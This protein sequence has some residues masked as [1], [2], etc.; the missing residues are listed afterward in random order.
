MTL[1]ILFWFSGRIKKRSS[2]IQLNISC[3]HACNTALALMDNHLENKWMSWREL[4]KWTPQFSDLYIIMLFLWRAL[5]ERV[6]LVCPNLW[7]MEGFNWLRQEP[8]TFHVGVF[9]KASDSF[10]HRCSPCILQQGVQ[11]THIWELP[12]CFRNHRWKR[13]DPVPLSLYVINFYE[14]E[15][16]FGPYFRLHFDLC[17]RYLCQWIRTDT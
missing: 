3:K 15:N 10:L 2:H 7:N 6:Y 9:W 16:S 14:F 4:F 1:I 13:V 5:R 12:F 17:Y 11:V 8:M